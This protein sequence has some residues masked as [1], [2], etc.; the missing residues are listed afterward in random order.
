MEKQNYGENFQEHLLEQY[1]LYV[2]MTDNN[3]ARRGQMNSFY[4]S[5]VFGLLAAISIFGSKETFSDFQEP[6]FKSITLLAVGILGLALCGVW[7]NNILSYRQLSSAKFKVIAEMEK[8]MP[9]PVYE[10]EWEILKKERTKAYLEQSFIERYIPLI[11]AI[12]YISLIIYSVLSF[13]K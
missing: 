1:L 12:P 8:Y 11:L 3:I 4:I 6:R 7:Y 2:E 13:T 5:V 10:R 9:F